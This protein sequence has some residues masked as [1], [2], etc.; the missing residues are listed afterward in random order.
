MSWGSSGARVSSSCA[1][2]ASSPHAE[3]RDWAPVISIAARAVWAL[4]VNF[5][6]SSLVCHPRT[7]AVTPDPLAR[8]VRVA[9]KRTAALLYPSSPLPR[10]GAHYERRVL[11][12]VLALRD[13]RRPVW[14]T[15]DVQRVC[16]L[17]SLRPG[18]PGARRRARRRARRGRE[19]LKSRAIG[20]VQQLA[21]TLPSDDTAPAATTAW[22]A[23]RT[24]DPPVQCPAPVGGLPG[25]PP[26]TW[27]QD[28]V[29]PA[30][31]PPLTWPGPA[32]LAISPPPDFQLGPTA[33][34]SSTDI[35]A[36]MVTDDV[37]PVSASGTDS[38]VSTDSIAVPARRIIPPPPAHPP[39]VVPTA[40]RREPLAVAAQPNCLT[41]F[42]VNAA[43]VRHKEPELVNIATWDMPEGCDAILVSETRIPRHDRF[44]LNVP[45]YSSVRTSRVPGPRGRPE[46]GGVAVLVHKRWRTRLLFRHAEPYRGEG[47]A[48]LMHDD[49]NV[50][51]VLLLATYL[52]VDMSVTNAQASLEQQCTRARRLAEQYRVPVVWGGDFNA[53]HPDWCTR[54]NPAGTALHA[55]TTLGG[56]K[57]WATR[58][59]HRAADTGVLTTIDHVLTRGVRG[60]DAGA[61]AL[62][63]RRVSGDHA[64]IRF[65][66]AVPPA[67]PV[68]QLR[69]RRANVL[70]LEEQELAD[71]LSTQVDAELQALY[72]ASPLDPEALSDH[73]DFLLD[74]VSRSVSATIGWLYSVPQA[75]RRP[76][77]WRLDAAA[78]RS[79]R[80]AMQSTRRVHQRAVQRA[81]PHDV[82]DTLS[83]A[84]RRARNR[85]THVKMRAKRRSYALLLEQAASEAASGDTRM[86]WRLS[87]QCVS[88]DTPASLQDL[89]VHWRDVAAGAVP[90]PGYVWPD[91]PDRDRVMMQLQHM[92][93]AVPDP[94]A[95]IDMDAVST[96][97]RALP[98]NKATLDN[99]PGAVYKLNRAALAQA[100]QPLLDGCWRSTWLPPAL[101]DLALVAVLKPDKDPTEPRSYRP[102][103]LQRVL[104]RIA[105]QVWLD[106][107]QG[108]VDPEPV[109]A[110][111]IAPVPAD[112]EADNDTS[113]TSDAA[114][115]SDD[116]VP[117]ADGDAVRLEPAQVPVPAAVLDIEAA[118][119]AG[120]RDLFNE[121]ETSSVSS[122]VPDDAADAAAVPLRLSDNQ[123]GFR[124]GRNTSQ[125]ALLLRA[126]TEEVD[127]SRFLVFLDA[128][129][130][131][132]SCDHGYPVDA[133]RQHGV[134]E[135]DV[136]MFA[137][138]VTS[139]T[140]VVRAGGQDSAPFPLQTGVPQ[141]APQSPL[142]YIAFVNM[143]TLGLDDV[144]DDD[145]K[146]T[147]STPDGLHSASAV[148]LLYADDHALITRTRA[149]AQQVLDALQQRSLRF[150]YAFN[151]S[152]S[153]AMYV[154]S[155]RPATSTADMARRAHGHVS[156]YGQRIPYTMEFVYLGFTI[157]AHNDRQAHGRARLASG[158]AALNRLQA[159]SGQKGAGAAAAR[160]LIRA[161]LPA[162]MLYGYEV[163]P[164]AKMLVKQMQSVMVQA[165]RK[166]LV[167][168][169]STPVNV[170]MIEGGITPMQLTASKRLIKFY[171]ALRCKAPDQRMVIAMHAVLSTRRAGSPARYL[172]SAEQELDT[173]VEHLVAE[174]P[175]PADEDKLD[176]HLRDMVHVKAGAWMREQLRWQQGQSSARATWRRAWRHTLGRTNLQLGQLLARGP[177]YARG[178]CVDA[179][180]VFIARS[181]RYNP[182]DIEED[183]ELGVPDCWLCGAVESDTPHHVLLHCDHVTLCRFRDRIMEIVAADDDLCA[184]AADLGC[185]NDNDS[186]LQVY[187]LTEPHDASAERAFKEK[188]VPL[189]ARMHRAI[190]KWRRSAH[191]AAGG[192]VPGRAVQL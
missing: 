137:H 191:D 29:L 179:R 176:E 1:H 145:E 113:A 30:G 123:F 162:T 7:L 11:A 139:T 182:Y 150:R 112:D 107:V 56:W 166:T 171:W 87:R 85:Y 114:G 111:L 18:V 37:G 45:G 95:T 93:A 147:I 14:L 24:A 178:G 129:K 156:M 126:L 49:D 141:G 99:L 119:L 146:V 127:E 160:M 124:R 38:V 190:W 104:G 74:G 77:W 71:Q 188:L 48:V 149:Q 80:A 2:S 125:A 50:P 4:G 52:P 170:L 138:R 35:L 20:H 148:L 140:A 33:A 128:T 115:D 8:L 34:A 105:D 25:S 57:R 83:V 92:L 67:A 91:C 161:K 168:Y 63:E 132:D 69:P 180:F 183:P 101:T 81:L 3:R 110:T 26:L 68:Q 103:A 94:G 78:L 75:P 44:P 12:A 165:A 82:I 153:R 186:W 21:S 136:R 143:A 135:L 117:D 97:V 169:R 108:V 100:V 98:P 177:E 73:A 120:L 22:D 6:V 96:V 23:V 51:V 65:R 133:L 54:R 164:A 187:L 106:R 61:E 9:W 152:K 173:T 62:W 167:A 16:D 32:R 88:T 17:V 13:S 72:A 41:V 43:G 122:F 118:A 5:Q 84:A 121:S 58:P 159:I 109:P 90:P 144:L 55:R 53:R 158:R 116:D 102:I 86:L 189:V 192:A 60:P 15:T 142:A 27:P 10:D 31:S 46:S 181:G 157:S 130:A 151:P 59:T 163:F 47:C 131:F 175:N 79:S 155:R 70:R 172:E 28:P 184:W 64:V 19:F 39:A 40:A 36:A 76:K 66:F 89:F 42:A 174:F 154:H 134:P 185:L